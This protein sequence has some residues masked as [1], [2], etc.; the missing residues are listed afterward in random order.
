MNPMAL[1]ALLAPI[2]GPA[3]VLLGKDAAPYEVD[4]RRLYQGHTP[5]VVRPRTTAQVAAVLRVCLRFR[6][7]DL[8]VGWNTR[9]PHTLC[10]V[11]VRLA[12]TF[13]IR[14]RFVVAANAGNASV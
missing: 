3:G 4:H 14:G 1:H 6:T 10:L 5:L 2:V 11:T 13:I 9:A 8:I 12:I 7:D